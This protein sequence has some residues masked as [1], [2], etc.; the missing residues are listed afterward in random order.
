M[1]DFDVNAGAAPE[2]ALSNKELKKYLSY[3]FWPVV[4][5]MVF[6]ENFL[7][8]L[9]PCL[10]LDWGIIIWGPIIFPIWMFIFAFTFW[11]YLPKRMRCSSCGK[12]ACGWRIFFSSMSGK[13]FL[14]TKCVYC[15][16]PFRTKW[17]M[18]FG[19]EAEN[20]PKG[21]P[22]EIETCRKWPIGILLV[23][24][25]VILFT[26]PFIFSLIKNGLPFDAALL[27]AFAHSPYY[28]LLAAV[29]AVYAYF[30]YP[31]LMR[32]SALNST[33]DN[34]RNDSGER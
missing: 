5:L 10:N 14:I 28:F 4:F 15:D 30:I 33:W 32:P 7:L 20:T 34:V 23:F 17:D 21:M 27:S 1:N 19:S 13:E 22:I 24:N 11:Y 25:A 31:K 2:E 8:A 29:G 3:R 18:P 6:T 9:L 12:P 26:S 16:A